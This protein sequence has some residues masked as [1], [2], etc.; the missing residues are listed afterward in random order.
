[1]LPG[2]RKPNFSA[3][4]FRPGPAKASHYGCGMRV[5][6][7]RNYRRR[8]PSISAAAAAWQPLPPLLFAFVAACSRSAVEITQHYLRGLKSVEGR[9]GSFLA[10]D[11]EG[12]L[13]QAAAIDARI[14]AGEEVGP[15]AGVPIAIKDNLCTQVGPLSVS[16][17]YHG[18]S[19]QFCNLWAD[20]RGKTCS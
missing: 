11:E 12:A 9:L 18:I 16:V 1:M 15:L 19:L 8:G 3:P 5:D 2:E 17:E 7:S 14:A 20:N 4:R 6:G 13:L 10:V